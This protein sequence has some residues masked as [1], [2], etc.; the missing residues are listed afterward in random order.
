VR[1]RTTGSR[2]TFVSRRPISSR[3][4][5]RESWKMSR[6]SAD[7]GMVGGDGLEPPTLSV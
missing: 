3:F 2:I 7:F 1:K 5:L 6:V 4:L